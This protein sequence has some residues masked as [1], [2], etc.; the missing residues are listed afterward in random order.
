MRR[1]N[2]HT[3]LEGL[4]W[5][6]GRGWLSS[7]ADTGPGKVSGAGANPGGLE[8]RWCQDRACL[9]GAAGHKVHH[10]SNML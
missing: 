2:P 10:V 3:S 5:L 8:K 1:G 4:T 9:K 6:E 7:T